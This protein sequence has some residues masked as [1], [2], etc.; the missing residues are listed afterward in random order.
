MGWYGEAGRNLPW[1]N[2]LNPYEIWVSEIILQQTRVNQGI[3]YY[4]RFLERFPDIF[5]LAGA[6]VEEVLKVWQG[7]G[8]Y[9]RARNMHEAAKDIVENYNGK[10]PDHFESLLR[11]KGIGRYTAAAIASIAFGEVVPAVDGN[12]K[13]VI[14]RIFGVTDDMKSRKGEAA[15]EEAARKIMDDSRPGM[16]NQ[17]LMDFGSRICTPRNPDCAACPLKDHCYAFRNNMTDILPVN[18]KNK[19][20]RMRYFYYFIMKNKQDILIEQRKD[21]DIWHLLYQFPLIESP[22]ELAEQDILTQMKERWFKGI[23]GIEIAGFSSGILHQLSHQLISA[24]FIHV[25]V[26]S[27]EFLP[28]GERFIKIPEATLDN[29]AI[30]RLIEKYLEVAGT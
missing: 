14:S 18:K 7:L 25:R 5:S 26:S 28:A 21:K 15:V 16:F 29:Y 13:R 6:R 1:R 3:N 27:P 30:P 10:F 8:Y 23:A 4:K 17:A 22:S 20:V 9:S 2:T 12:V 24:R 19:A 11:L